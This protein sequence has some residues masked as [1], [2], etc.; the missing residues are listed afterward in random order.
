[1]SL[2]KQNE[3]FNTFTIELSV[4]NYDHASSTNLIFNNEREFFMFIL[5]IFLER[6][7]N[8]KYDIPKYIITIQHF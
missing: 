2:L 5:R 4:P 7:I 3:I 1:M 8:G 6:Q